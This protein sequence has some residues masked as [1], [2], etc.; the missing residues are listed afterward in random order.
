LYRDDPPQAP[1]RLR[2]VAPPN[3]INLHTLQ[4]L[5]GHRP[6]SDAALRRDLFLAYPN[7]RDEVGSKLDAPVTEPVEVSG[8]AFRQA[9][10]SGSTLNDRPFAA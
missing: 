2:A 5:E 10:R 6:L 3:Y 8:A 7:G 4:G 9:A 1:A